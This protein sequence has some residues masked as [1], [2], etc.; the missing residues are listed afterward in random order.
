MSFE[1][2]AASLLSKF[3]T[4]RGVNVGVLDN[5]GPWPCP[6]RSDIGVHGLSECMLYRSSCGDNGGGGDILT[7]EECP[8]FSWDI[9][10]FCV[11]I[12]SSPSSERCDGNGILSKLSKLNASCTSTTKPHELGDRLHPGNSPNSKRAHSTS[13]AM[14]LVGSC[15]PNP[16]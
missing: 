13:T 5:H 3:N 15:K 8:M 7:G 4:I 2:C 6:S 9:A 16:Q 14:S 12:P 10:R 1:V 11:L